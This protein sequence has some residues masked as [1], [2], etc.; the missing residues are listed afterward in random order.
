M[1]WRKEY[2]E[3]YA[4]L[5]KQTKEGAAF[6]VCVIPVSAIQNLI[7]DGNK[8]NKTAKQIANSLNRW[9]EMANAAV[10]ENTWPECCSCGA[11]VARD[12]VAGWVVFLPHEPNHTGMMGVFC[13]V[14]FELGSEVITDKTVEHMMEFG[15]VLSLH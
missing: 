13:P 15:Q 11:K 9:F 2:D 1:D 8:G 3:G 12:E 4:A 14:C 10:M 6:S 5:R 7:E